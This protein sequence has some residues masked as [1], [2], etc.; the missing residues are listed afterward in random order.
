MSH[1][2]AQPLVT[3]VTICWNAIDSIGRT[4]DSV[5]AQTYTNVEHLLVDGA[6]TDGTVELIRERM[7]VQDRL[8]SEPDNGISDA[9]NKSVREARGDYIQFLHA[10]DAMPPDFIENAVAVL[11]ETNAPFAYGD[12]IMEQDGAAAMHYRGEPHYDTIIP[13]RMPNLNHPTCVHKREMFDQVGPFDTDLKCAMDYDWFLRAAKLGLIGTYS[14]TMVAHMN[15]DGVSN[16]AFGR[17]I[18]EVRLIA[19]RHGRSSI[20]A[21]AEWLYRTVKTNLGRLVKAVA[22][23]AYF[24]L[25]SLINPTVKT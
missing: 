23:D 19:V 11:Q 24:K 9:L 21:R 6:S 17:T 7:R 4:I 3:V 1:P 20:I 14:P 25:R 15:I 18:N 5:Q 10:D 8:I 16:T 22:G 13:R 2:T 12:L